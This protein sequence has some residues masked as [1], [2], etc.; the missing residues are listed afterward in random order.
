MHVRRIERQV[1]AGSNANFKDATHRKGSN[2]FAVGVKG[3]LSHGHP[4][5]AGQYMLD[6][7]AH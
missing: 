7:A 5:K 6:I 3:L 1:D 4:E 2:A